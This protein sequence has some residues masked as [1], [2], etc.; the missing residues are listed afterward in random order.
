MAAPNPS[1]AKHDADWE[2]DGAVA[3]NAVALPDAF[4]RLLP[5]SLQCRQVK[6]PD[7]DNS[8]RMKTLLG[9]SPEMVTDD[10]TAAALCVDSYWPLTHTEA[11]SRAMSPVGAAHTHVVGGETYWMP[12]GVS[13]A[14]HGE[15]G[16]Q[17]PASFCVGGYWPLTLTEAASKAM[18]PS[19]SAH[20]HVVDG[21]TYFMPDGVAGDTHGEQGGSSC[22]TSIWNLRDTSM[23]VVDGLRSLHFTVDL[24]PTIGLNALHLLFAGGSSGGASGGASG[25]SDTSRLFYH[26]PER[27]GMTLDLLRAHYRYQ[28]L[29]PPAAPPQPSCSVGAVQ[30]Y[31]LEGYPCGLP[32]SPS[33]DLLYHL[34]ES[35]PRMLRARLH[36]RLCTGWIAL[37]FA[38]SPGAM[39][40]ASAIVATESDVVA[41]DLIDRL[42]EAVRPSRARAQ[43]QLSGTSVQR[44]ERGVTM[45]FTAMVG[46]AGVP[47]SLGDVSGRT[48]GR[49]DGE[50]TVTELIF[51]SGPFASDEG[52]SNAPRGPN[53]RIQPHWLRRASTPF[54]L[55]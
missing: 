30:S 44:D 5:P 10:A 35:S 13:G 47:P 16:A 23:E 33:I 24:P 20:T 50:I 2:H 14:M 54:A 37:G 41:Y 6:L 55:L 49:R 11:A 8:I 53:Q 38:S 31:N 39:S 26:G 17:C 29:P 22:P 19:G 34:S 15:E 45:E 32:L 4:Y 9:K 27:G 48:G 1:F 46:E 36:C 21:A 7:A 40:G 51:A 12:D 43:Q 25:A 3:P 28:S 42:A 18:S 52:T